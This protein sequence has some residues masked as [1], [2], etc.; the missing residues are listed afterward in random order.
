MRSR[1]LPLVLVATPDDSL[2]QDLQRILKSLGMRVQLAQ[3]SELA[4]TA[5]G[6]MLGNG[7]TDGIVLLDVRMPGVAEG[8][9]LAAIHESGMNRRCAIALIADRVADEWIARLREGVIDDIVP[10]SADVVGWKTHLSTMQRG[11][12][13]SRELEQLRQSAVMEVQHD[14]VTGA[15]NRETM[16]SILFR[17][18]DRVQRLHGALCLVVFDV[19]DFNHW[20]RELGRDECDLLLREIATRTGRVLRSYDLLGRLGN[21]EFLLALPGCSMI[22]AVMLAERLRMDVFGEPFMVSMARTDGPKEI[23]SVRLSASFGITASRGRSPVVVLREAEEAMAMARVAGP[24]SIRC[25]NDAAMAAGG[26]NGL[27]ATTLYPE[28]QFQF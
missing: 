5:M 7:D 19:D 1:K 18:T 12:E 9:L 21:D 14:R 27:T 24:N 17:E 3:N 6:T 2:A 4:M 26:P 8:Q 15:F 13:L 16:L 23:F 28:R 10:R 11:H 20:N 25:A 22:N